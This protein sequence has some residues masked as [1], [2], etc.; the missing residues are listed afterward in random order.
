MLQVD[1]RTLLLGQ[2]NVARHHQRLGNARPTA[3]AERGRDRALVHVAAVRQRRLLLVQGQGQVERPY[4][5]QGSA[6][7]SC[8]L[9][10][11]A[12]VGKARGTAVGE[13][14]HL[15]QRF[16]RAPDANRGEEADLDDGAFLGA[17]ERGLERGARVDHRIGIRHREDRRVATRGSRSRAGGAILFVFLAGH[18]QVHVWIDEAGQQGLAR[19]L[20]D[21]RAD[22]SGNLVADLDDLAVLDQQVG[23][24]IQPLDGVEQAGALDEDVDGVGLALLEA[25]HAA[26]HSPVRSRMSMTVPIDGRVI[27]S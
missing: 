9:D 26:P 23:R 12:V 15:C 8:A 3:E 5:L 10:R 16:A 14:A 17:V 4:V 24:H 19:A 6:H 22:G 25:G 18:T 27:R 11:R 20:Q 13:V 2:A 21:A 1:T 7:Q